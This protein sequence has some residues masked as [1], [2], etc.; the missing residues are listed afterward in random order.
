MSINFQ[1]ARYLKSHP[2]P[3]PQ[4][5][6]ERL[7][8]SGF[9]A[10]GWASLALATSAFAQAPSEVITVVATGNPLAI[11]K[12]GQP[13]TVITADQ[14]ATLQGPDLTRA[15]ERIPGLALSRNGG[16]GA[17]TGVRLRGSESEQLL[18][19][20]DGVRVE[21]V[22]APSGGFDFGTLTTGGVERI[23]VLRG[24]N[25]VVW[26]SA[27]IG[28][29]VAVTSR[30][31]NGV[32]ATAEAGSR[33]S[34][35]ADA[36]A[37]LSGKSGSLTLN[38]GY[39]TTD[40]I[41]SAATGTEADGF[42][43]WRI[44]GKGRVNLTDALSLI[45]TARYA[46]SHVDI[47]GFPAPLYA[48]A[49]TPEYQVTR[50][51]SGRAAARYQTTAFRLEA[52]YALSET[53]RDYYDPTFGTAPSY[54]YR[55]HSERA[56]LTGHVALPQDL[57]VDFGADS[58]WTRYS[59]TFDAERKARLSSAHAML[60]WYG[61]GATIAAGARID[62]HSRFGSQWTFGANGTVKL[63]ANLRL[64][65]SFGEGFKAPTL[66][67]LLSDY[68]NDLLAPEHTRSYD[69]GL[70]W[71]GSQVRAAITVY[72]R[73]SRDLIAYDSCFGVTGGIC[74]NR[75]FGT[76]DNIGKARAEGV[77]AEVEAHPTPQFTAR[78][79][80]TYDKARNL[81]AGSANLG[82]DLARRP[83]HALTAS[84]D[85]TTPLHQLALGADMRFVSQSFDDAGNFTRL[86]GG[87]QTTLRASLPVTS[88]IELHA[89]VENLFNTRV[90][91]AAGYGAQGRSVF[92]GLRVRY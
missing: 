61:D 43:Q 30:E 89:R 37:G 17:F 25:S 12:S 54:G 84:V 75:P 35:T 88:R 51:L 92:G 41:S 73:D 66:F 50:Q 32:D 48:F 15:L 42:H 62:D 67:Q 13:I 18:V 14:L 33:G 11:D 19:L 34:Y 57:A 1:N 47:D 26:G 49:D 64:R 46:D 55:G 4:A 56:D 65:A 79:A 40:G 82:N 39:T 74:T 31:L 27:A 45:A 24:S 76:Y 90:P 91:T 52:G 72:R 68:G 81:T 44:G 69:A 23:D 63:P 6:G 78:L 9:V 59:G 60:G 21:D 70:E 77:E 87:S 80:Y 58:E 3:L 20:V 22:S 7:R 36:T 53:K 71:S 8:T 28:G 83:R 38:G 10:A 29:V 16:T 85:W 5:G 2:Q 86:E